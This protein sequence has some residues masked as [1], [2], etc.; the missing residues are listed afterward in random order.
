MNNL[1]AILEKVE[2]QYILFLYYLLVTTRIHQKQMKSLFI[3]SGKLGIAS[4]L[5]VQYHMVI[6]QAI[7]SHL[8]SSTTLKLFP[9]LSLAISICKITYVRFCLPYLVCY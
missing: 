3:F 4:L 9:Y 8:H 5:G 7:T 1:N 6:F 2:K